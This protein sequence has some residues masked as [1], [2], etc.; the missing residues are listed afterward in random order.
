MNDAISTVK[1]ETLLSESF[2]Y[3]YTGDGYQLKIV[4]VVETSKAFVT[5]EVTDEMGWGFKSSPV[6]KRVKKTSLLT[7]GK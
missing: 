4:S 7:V 2:N 1:A 3:L 5:V 6:K